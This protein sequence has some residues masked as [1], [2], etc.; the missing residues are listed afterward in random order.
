MANEH[1]SA[2]KIANSSAFRQC[3]RRDDAVA[4][5]DAVLYP[6]QA[7]AVDAQLHL[8]HQEG[9]VAAIE[10]EHLAGPAVDDG[11]LGNDQDV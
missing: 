6:P 5:L 7:A 3:P 4:V 9:T 8:A 1:E 10:H 2:A 11:L